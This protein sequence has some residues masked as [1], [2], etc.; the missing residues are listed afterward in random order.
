MKKRKLSKDKKNVYPLTVLRT[1]LEQGTTILT[2]PPLPVPFMPSMPLVMDSS[3]K[4]AAT[5]RQVAQRARDSSSRGNTSTSRD[6]VSPLQGSSVPNPTPRRSNRPFGSPSG[7]SSS[8]SLSV[9]DFA[10]RTQI[11][12]QAQRTAVRIEELERDAERETQYADRD[13]ATAVRVTE[14]LPVEHIY[15]GTVARKNVTVRRSRDRLSGRPLALPRTPEDVLRRRSLDRPRDK[16]SDAQEQHVTQ[17]ASAVTHIRKHGEVLKVS[18]SPDRED[19]RRPYLSGRPV[20]REY[21]AQYPIHGVDPKALQLVVVMRMIKMVIKRRI[22]KKMK[23]I[24]LYSC[25]VTYRRL[26]TH[27]KSMRNCSVSGN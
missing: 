7:S 1:S 12:A 2:Y 24:Y 11:E 18:Y 21:V 20:P 8:L 9:L 25:V 15:P 22:F 3:K 19:H 13:E 6:G 23:M 17:G 26:L 27:L 4:E 5:P 16:R 14:E 10:R